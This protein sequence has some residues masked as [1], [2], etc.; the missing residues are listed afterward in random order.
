MDLPSEGIPLTNEEVWNAVQP[1]LIFFRNER[2]VSSMQ[3]VNTRA[4]VATIFE[5]FDSLL[6]ADFATEVEQRLKH[7][8]CTL[9][10]RQVDEIAYTILD[11]RCEDSLDLYALCLRISQQVRGIESGV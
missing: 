4:R 6:V 10:S 1:S 9:S 7:R 2:G 3:F 11:A 8:G 5:E